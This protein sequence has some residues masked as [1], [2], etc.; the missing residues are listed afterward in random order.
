[1]IVEPY[2]FVLIYLKLMNSGVRG[3]IVGKRVLT[4]DVTGLHKNSTDNSW[5][6]GG[7]L[8]L[9][10]KEIRERF[11]EGGYKHQKLD[12]YETVEHTQYNIFKRSKNMLNVMYFPHA[13]MGVYIKLY[14]YIC[15]YLKYLEFLLSLFSEWY[16]KHTEYPNLKSY[17]KIKFKMRALTLIYHW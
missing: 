15:D 2:F 13:L 17:F 12:M 8:R 5:T 3:G 10:V 7:S 1:M 6:S 4:D 16:E 11:S 9:V 14:L